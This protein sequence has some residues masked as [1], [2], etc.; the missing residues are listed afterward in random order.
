MLRLAAIFVAICIVLIA[1]AIAA[2]LYLTLGLSGAES[3]TVGIAA[4]TG[5]LLYNQIT[6]RLRDRNDIGQQIADLSRLTADLAKHMAEI[7][8]SLAAAESKVDGAVNRVRAAVEPV[9][10]EIGDLGVLVKQLADTVAMHDAALT[11]RSAPPPEPSVLEP[12][13][14][15]P[16]VAPQAAPAAAGAGFRSLD[17]DAMLASIREAIESNRMDLYLQ[18]I[19]TLPQRKVRYYEAL[20]RLRTAAGEQ[21]MA[22]DFVPHAEASGLM[23]KIDN[24]SVFRCVQILRRLLMKNRDVGLFCNMASATLADRQ[25]FQQFTEF[26]E[27]NRALAPALMFEFRQDAYR[28]MTPLEHESLA[29]L[30]GRGFRFSMD[31]VTDLRLDPQELADRGFR[32]LKVPAALL[33]RSGGP[34][35]GDIHP[36]DLSELLARN[37]IDLIAERIE[38]ES[39]VVDL[40][41]FDVRFGQGFLFSQPRPVRQEAMQGAN[42]GNGGG[43]DTAKEPKPAVSDQPARMP[44]INDPTAPKLTSGMDV[45]A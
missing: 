36:A 5:M 28:A 33:L 38:N 39:A 31:H 4:L 26:M 9:T 21:V 1:G 14:P 34:A 43:S 6:T 27:A 15:A 42:G 44:S 30:A 19:V 13:T 10:T 2:I 37:H 8:R 22:E 17:N 40:L 3:A 20:T 41:D 12:E 32:F 29:A 23:P 11:A 7:K 16:S 25:L 35:N 18:P 45:V 24:L